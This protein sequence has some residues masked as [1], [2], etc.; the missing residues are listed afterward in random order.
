M[1]ST[2]VLELLIYQTA[3]R[4]GLP[5]LAA[6]LSVVVLAFATVLLSVQSVLRHRIER[7]EG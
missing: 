7:M 6:A 1:R 4:D 3:F 5:N 2:Y